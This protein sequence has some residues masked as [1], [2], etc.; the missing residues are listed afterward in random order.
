MAVHPR[1]AVRRADF[2]RTFSVFCDESWRM[3]GGGS[4][5]VALGAT[6]CDTACV[7]SYVES[8]RRLKVRY[9]FRA[10][11]VTG[12]TK[13]SPAKAVFYRETIDMFLH[14]DNLRFVGLIGES[15]KNPEEDGRVP[16]HGSR[17]E[18]DRRLLGAVL[19]GPHRYRVYTGVT[20][21]RGGARLR[22]LRE[23]VDALPPGDDRPPGD[24]RPCV[25]RI[26]QIRAGE[27]ELL[28]LTDLLTGALAYANR[29]LG[30]NAGKAAIVARLR[31]RFGQDAPGDSFAPHDP[32]FHVST[33]R[34]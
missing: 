17:E 1:N 30:G 28:Q 22:R 33:W 21:T 32:K 9:G 12:W 29:G 11:F 31:E 18:L 25:E 2:A 27:S 10:G 26:Q 5:F 19:Q 15:G 6:V 14:R 16:R 3:T 20:D 23:T 7:R 13:I 24:C 4:W 8:A 34:L